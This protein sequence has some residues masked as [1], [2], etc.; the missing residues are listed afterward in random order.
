[1]EAYDVEIEIMRGMG[2]AEILILWE[3]L[4]TG[5]LPMQLTREQAVVDEIV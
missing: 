2:G 4:D 3:L 1:M 5:L